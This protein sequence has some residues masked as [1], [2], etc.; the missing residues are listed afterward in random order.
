[1]KYM[2]YKDNRK[3]SDM[4]FS[5]VEA[6]KIFLEN[7]SNVKSSR[8]NSIYDIYEYPSNKRV[9]RFECRIVDGKSLQNRILVNMLLQKIDRMVKHNTVYDRK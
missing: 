8:N 4:K 6:A 7:D 2:I 1:M 3:Y 9:T 5:N